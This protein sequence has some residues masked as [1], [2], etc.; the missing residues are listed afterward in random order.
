MVDWISLEAGLLRRGLH[1]GSRI[2]HLMY[3]NTEAL[4][5]L[6]TIEDMGLLT[7]A[8]IVGK[9]LP[10]KYFDISLWIGSN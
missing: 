9:G 8:I 1:I 4:K 10:P 2:D 6:R 3:I 5:P 7:S